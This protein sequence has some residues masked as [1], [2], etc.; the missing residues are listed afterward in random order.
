M[1]NLKFLL[2]GLLAGVFTLAIPGFGAFDPVN[3]DT[4]IFLNNP[5]VPGER[6]NILI[7]LDNT[8]N[9]NN[10]FANEKSALVSTVNGLDDRYNLGLMLYPE[11]GG[12][13]DSIDGGYMRFGVRQMTSTNKGALS[14]LVGNLDKLGDKGNNSTLSLAMAEAYYFFNAKTNRASF[15]KVKTD[16]PGNTGNSITS[17]LGSSPLPANPTAA[18][19]YNN[20]IANAC[21]RN[22]IIYISNGPASENASALSTSQTLLTTAMGQ[23]PTTIGINPNG[24]QSNWADEWAKFMSGSS[25]PVI[26]YTVEVDPGSQNQDLAMTALMKSM[27]TN[28]GGKYFAVSSSSGGTQISDALNKIFTEVQAVNSVFASTTL[29]V[30]VNVRGTNINQVY[31]GVF[32][33]DS[34]LL[35]RWY[36]NLKLYQVGFDTTTSKIFL[37]D[38][39]GTRADNA[40]SGFITNTAQSFWTSSSTFWGFR[41]SAQNGAGGDSDSPDGDLVEK[42]GAAQMLRVP[43]ATDQSTRT[44]YTCTTGS[45]ANC[46]S[47]SSL[48][49][50]PF[51]TANTDITGAALNLGT[52]ALSP[53]TGFTT[54]TMTSIVD[55]LSAV[56]DNSGTSQVTISA[57]SNGATSRSVTSLTTA[58]P[59]AITALTAAVTGSATYNLQLVSKSGNTYTWT[60][61]TTHGF[62]AGTTVTFSGMAGTSAANWNNTSYVISSPTSNTFQMSRTGSPG[63][64]F[65]NFGSVSGNATV[66]T[67]TATATV[68]GHG[69]T[70]STKVTVA[71]ASSPFNVTNAT[72]TAVTT[73]TFSYTITPAAGVAT[74]LGTASGATTTATVTTSVNHGFSNGDSILIAGANPSGY[75]NSGTRVTIANASGNSFTYTVSS[76]LAPNT[77]T[78]VTATKFSGGSTVTGTT[79]ASLYAAPLNLSFGTPVTLNIAGADSGYNGSFTITP[80]SSTSFTYDPGVYL[81]PNSTASATLSTGTSST[82]TATAALH[83]FAVNDFV[84]IEGASPAG[85]NGSWQVLSVPTANTF[86]YSTGSALAAP[87]GA[88][89]VRPTSAGKA[90]VTK[91]AHGYT[92]GQ[93]VTIAGATPTGYNGA[94]TLTRLSADVFSVPLTSAPGTNTGS[95]VT[96]SL[97]TTTASAHSPAHGFA[98]NDSV[99]VSGATPSTFNG[100]FNITVVDGSNFTYT[101]PSA[102]GDASGVVVASSS[103]GASSSQRT[104]LIN[105]VRGQDNQED[106]NANGSLTDVR[107]SIH[108]D[109][110]HSQPAVVNYNRRNSDAPNKDNDVYIYYG[111]NDG[112]FRAVKGGTGSTTGDP[113]PGREVWGFIPTEFFGTLDRLRTNSPLLS[114]LQKKPYFADGS[115]GAY[116]KDGN[117]DGA[118]S[119]TTS[120]VANLYIS[121]RRGGR[122]IYALNV[123]DPLTPKFLWKK[124]NT[125]MG[126]SELGQ[127][128]SQPQVIPSINASTT[129][130][131]LFGAGYDDQVEDLQTSAITGSTASSIT[132]AA[133]TFN[134]GMG[135]GIYMLNALTGAIIWQAAG[136]ARAVADTSTHPY[137]V[138]SGM[139]CSI[140][141]DIAVTRNQG[142]T[143][144]YNRGYAVDSCG[145]VWRLDFNDADPANWKVTKLAAIGGTA[146][147][148]SR[149]K[150]QFAPDVV[151]RTGYDAVLLGSGDREHPFDT[152]VTNRFYMIKDYAKGALSTDSSGVALYPT[153]TE[154]S[155][156]DATS[157]CIQ[158]PTGCPSGVT[159]S[160]ATASLNAAAGWYVTLG[161]GEKTVGGALAQSG[162]VIFVTNQPATVAT[163]GVCTSNLGTARTYEVSVDNATATLDL[164]AG[165]GLTTADRSLVYAGG[166]Y[167]PSPVPVVVQITTT[168]TDAAGNVTTGTKTASGAFSG[169]NPIQTPG[170]ALNTRVRKFWFKEID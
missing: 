93:S 159:A 120:D 116:V 30:S 17:S 135:R 78:G 170:P 90:W 54:Q 160:I 143:S 141:A 149:R 102:E 107:S 121:M 84:T 133:G 57:F 33:P 31:I 4:D 108:G 154:A 74:T 156:Y 9:W 60:T 18:S 68:P 134:R 103:S 86:T 150:F 55:R 164:S 139:D 165:G 94:A 158:D 157:N 66:N 115:I 49:V 112:I 35:P 123:L 34:D 146:S 166:G 71:G 80:T 92:T 27:A 32:R 83:G 132:T 58:T 111:S 70:L 125:D 137:L 168:S 77:A 127:T 81:P 128:W 82:V 3:D 140:S 138:V 153:A 1:K 114:S 89:T 105:W 8:A 48:S 101:I 118:L 22:F 19:A 40:A 119:S 2:L 142:N 10:A 117:N 98:T 63:V 152:T 88:I 161:S 100:T 109:V 51:S 20:P 5:N 41:T 65:S 75:N 147:N 155:L 52:R 129:P 16:W 44:L 148:A 26:T 99:T 25:V 72:L 42:G 53:L 56:L 45:Y 87:S 62:T 12:G 13:N 67:T 14:T 110:L 97:K 124:V 130:V 36:G 21:Q 47:G 15:G 23:A 106:E 61:T 162:T 151:Y 6:P 136:Q 169:P 167:L 73:D 126:M 29:P 43:Y 46:V 85:H 91:V 76:A 96:A 144:V 38:A 131:L 28:S 79:S 95:T 24:M 145:N 122:F 64:T 163:A 113:S 69:Y 104:A 7:I 50:T 37:A 59:K 11:T 39:N